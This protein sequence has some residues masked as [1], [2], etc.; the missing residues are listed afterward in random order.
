[1]KKNKV[2]QS[3]LF[4][5]EVCFGTSPLGD[6]PDTYG[7]NVS[8]ERAVR[9]IKT[10]I[11]S[12]INFIDTSRNYGMGRS[13]ERLGLAIADNSFSNND[14]IISTKLDRNMQT[15]KFDYRQAQSSFEKSLRAL[16]VES[17]PILHLHDPEYASNLEDI[18]AKGGALDFLFSLK[19]QG[20]VKVVG[21]AMGKLEIMEPLLKD[22]PF[23]AIISHN[24]FSI[25]N[26][27]ADALFSYAYDNGI[28][29]FNAAPYAGGIL[30]KG[31]AQTNRL[32]YQ[33]ASKEK[34]TPVYRVEEI[35]RDYNI[36]LGAVALQF[37][38]RDKRITSTIV[39]V[40]KP[41]RIKETIS[42]ANFPISKEAWDRLYA[43]P[44]STIDPELDRIYLAC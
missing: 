35:C 22:R 19:D 8:E 28:S 27:Q 4:V 42:W 21:L 23:D 20:L 44:F 36:P 18:T 1:M 25:L 5:T 11:E 29:I 31:S 39:G 2:G 6:M 3:D 16:N 12:P 13:E 32:V 24:R 10:I 26:R 14:L 7:Y 43:L 33:E 38:L 40:S 37:S 17:V 30:A 15:N 9:T 34:L 41:E